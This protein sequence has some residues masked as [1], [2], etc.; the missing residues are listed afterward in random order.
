MIRLKTLILRAAACSSVTAFPSVLLAQS[1]APEYRWVVFDTANVL[2]KLA[3]KV[4]YAPRSIREK[5][6]AVSVWL[7]TENY[8]A[9]DD[10][11][12]KYY[13]EFAIDC[14]TGYARETAAVMDRF[15]RGKPPR[16]GQ[17]RAGFNDYPNVFDKPTLL[18][19]RALASLA[20]KHCPK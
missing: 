5:G 8:R 1:N 11:R 19:A 6:G 12:E 13:G 7:L 17:R 9:A 10:Y 14:L 3:R 20:R 16:Y 4:S 15:G 2:G 18:E